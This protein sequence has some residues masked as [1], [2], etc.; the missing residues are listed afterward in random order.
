MSK[1]LRVR[2]R[3]T[4]ILLYAAAIFGS[5]SVS[6]LLGHQASCQLS[7]G[8]SEFC[9]GF[10][11]VY[12][13]ITISVM[14]LGATMVAFGVTERNDDYKTGMIII[15]FSIVLIGSGLVGIFFLGFD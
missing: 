12:S 5:L 11:P 10:T 6:L 1:M 13:L 8:G 14:T 15:G 4:R 7:D 3:N 2:N 9:R